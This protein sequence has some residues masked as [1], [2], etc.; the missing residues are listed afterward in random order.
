MTLKRAFNLA[1]K[2]ELTWYPESNS[3]AQIKIT[4]A[5]ARERSKVML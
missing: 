2:F 5:Q 1:T 4:K 3:S